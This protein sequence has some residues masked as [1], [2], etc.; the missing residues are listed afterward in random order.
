MLAESGLPDVSTELRIYLGQGRAIT[1]EDGMSKDGLYRETEPL[2]RLRSPSEEIQDAFD[3]LRT[4]VLEP[5]QLIAEAESIAA[6]LSDQ[7]GRRE[8]LLVDPRFPDSEAY[9]AVTGEELAAVKRLA[10]LLPELEQMMLS[11][12]RLTDGG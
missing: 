9:P 8:I 6:T 4:Q 12:V 3:Y 5:P 2:R 7:P 10:A 1:G 11:E